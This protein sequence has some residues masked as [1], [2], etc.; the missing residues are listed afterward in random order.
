MGGHPGPVS[1]E[2]RVAKGRS[3]EVTYT[4]DLVDADVVAT[5]VAGLARE[6][7][8]LGASTTAAASPTW[9]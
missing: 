6:R 2:P 1:A 9:R 4:R 8:A 5:E 3:R 7:H